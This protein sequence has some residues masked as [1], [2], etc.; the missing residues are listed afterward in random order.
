MKKKVLA[1]IPARAG[2]KRVPNKNLKSLAGIPLIGHTISAAKESQLFN[3]IIV[4]TD[5]IEIQEIAKRFGAEA[6]FVRPKEL[7]TDDAR[8]IDVILH[9]V[10]YIEELSGEQPSFDYLMVLQ[11]TSPLRTAGDILAA[12]QLCLERNADAVVSVAECE[13]SPLFANVLPEDFCLANFMNKQADNK[14]AQELPKYYRLNGAIY[15]ARWEYLK[16]NS[17]WYSA[18]SFAYVMP[19]ERSVDID[20]PFDFKFA[21]LLLEERNK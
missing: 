14:N 15:L 21:E 11:P 4:S 2:S 20:L 5:S 3:R 6:P 17:S 12:Y 18:R 16:Q 19:A 9:C 1:I 8:G 10:K 13:H 7:A